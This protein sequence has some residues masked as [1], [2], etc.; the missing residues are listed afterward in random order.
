MPLLSL[1]IK[2]VTGID[3]HIGGNGYLSF[4][5]QIVNRSNRV[6]SY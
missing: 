3:I 2:H 5:N 6:V 4:K 1:E